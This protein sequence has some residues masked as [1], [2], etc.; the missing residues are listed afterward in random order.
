[1]ARFDGI[2]EAEANFRD[3]AALFEPQLGG[4]GKV[5]LLRREIS[6]VLGEAAG[7][8]SA[9]AKSNARSQGVPDRVVSSI[10]T[11]ANPAKDKPKRAGALVGVNK[12]STMITWFASKHPKSPKAKVPPGGKVSMSLASM[13]EGGTTNRNARP[14]FS[15]ALKSMKGKAL[16]HIL[17]GYKSILEKFGN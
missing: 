6:R 12:R 9:E 1:M 14:F 2:K 5:S 11:F 13:F 16:D 10:F 7:F 4:S 3:L 17:A 15:P 8:I